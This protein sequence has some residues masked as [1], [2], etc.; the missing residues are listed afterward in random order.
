MKKIIV[1]LLIC[2]IF[3]EITFTQDFIE[4]KSSSY[5]YDLI[6]VS[7]TNSYYSFYK[8]GILKEYK[9]EIIRGNQITNYIYTIKAEKD[10]FL[11]H[12]IT[13]NDYIS[14]EPNVECTYKL[15]KI[16]NGYTISYENEEFGKL[17]FDKNDN[18]GYFFDY[19]TNNEEIFYEKQQNKC[20]IYLNDKVVYNLKNNIFYT[21]DNNKIKTDYNSYSDN[22]VYEITFEGLKTELSFQKKYIC[23]NN[24]NICLLWIMRYDIDKYILPYL[25]YNFDYSYHATSYLTEGTTTYEPEHLQQKDGLPWAS[26]NGKGIGDV[27]SITDF[28]HKKTTK[29][30]L[31]NGY[32]DSKH[33]EYYENNSRIKKIKITNKDTKK[34]KIYEI[35]DIKEEQSFEISELGFG[36]NYDI[37]VL[38]VYNGKKYTDL[39]IQYM[40]LE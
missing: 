37:E 39:C 2:I 22:Y 5:Q 9:K 3:Q 30:I 31:M 28:E 27:I 11:I 8:D 32:Q 15:K 34:T 10:Y 13:E 16:D 35:K 21:Q 25:L 12:L 38:E 6:P 26:G 36:N 14:S 40:V 1:F 24:E 17:Y 7:K 29:I 23:T 20:I 19:E 33:P 4:Y 18:R